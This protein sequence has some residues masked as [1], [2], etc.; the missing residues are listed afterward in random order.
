M[1]AWEVDD[2]PAAVALARK[3][4]FTVPDP[5]TGVLPG[6]CTAT[7]PAAEL[8]GVAMQLLQYS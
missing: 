3:A 1:A 4:G 2:L 5:A 6:T 7:I 8:G